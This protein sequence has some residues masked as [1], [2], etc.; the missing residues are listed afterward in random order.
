MTKDEYIKYFDTLLDNN[1]TNTCSLLTGGNLSTDD[2]WDILNYIALRAEVELG[3]RVVFVSSIP[4]YPTEVEMIDRY[5]DINHNIHEYNNCIFIANLCVYYSSFEHQWE[6][7]II[8]LLNYYK[9]PVFGFCS[10]QF[11]AIYE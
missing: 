11:L 8:K 2:R 10:K 3:K 4:T 5:T 7:S 6:D 1:R 9:Y